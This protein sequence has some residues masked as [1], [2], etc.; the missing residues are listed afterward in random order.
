MFRFSRW[1]DR[2]TFPPR[3]PYRFNNILEYGKS[4]IR[5]RPQSAELWPEAEPRAKD[6]R[7]ASIMSGPDSKFNSSVSVVRRPHLTLISTSVNDLARLIGAQYRRRITTTR[8]PDPI[9]P[10]SP[11]GFIPPDSTWNAGCVLK[12]LT[13]RKCGWTWLE[14][15][16]VLPILAG[17]VYAD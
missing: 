16:S 12:Q 5:C 8:M 15:G 2:S 7:P 4:S 10:F 14:P 11:A 17:L 13:A 3:Y 6:Y 9:I 1:R